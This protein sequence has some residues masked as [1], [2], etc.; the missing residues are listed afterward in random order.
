MEGFG[1][2]RMSPLRERSAFTLIELL[3]ILAIVGVL[4]ALLLVAV[5]RA[6]EAAARTQ[7][8]NNLR[9]ISLAASNFAASHDGRLPNVAGKPGSL[10]PKQSILVTLLP[11]V[12]QE[13]LYNL[14]ASKTSEALQPVRIYM[15]PSDPSL[16]Y[17]R[18]RTW[19]SSYAANA[20]VFTGNP[21]FSSTFADGT[22]NTIVF[23][24][25]YAYCNAVIFSYE[26]YTASSGHHRA[27][28]A[29][30]GPNVEQ[31]ENP[32]DAY[33]KT[34]GYPPVSCSAYGKDWTFQVMPIIDPPPGRDP[35]LP[36][37]RKGCDPGLANTPHPG[38]MLTAWG[39]G[40]VRTIARGVSP[41]VYWGAVSP[42]SGEI[43][44][45]GW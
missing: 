26:E 9:Q 19:V 24:E 10:N 45:L 21:S 37:M 44:N 3:V 18:N 39:D 29:D 1:F 20:Q 4:L 25:H 36:Y 28:F 30:G 6:R 7:S 12:G 16:G 33:P 14:Y 5:Q 38:G 43:L 35:N 15:S 11:Y 41:H 31:H 13:N 23:G 27:T 17:L 8:M 34:Q 2:M 42:A 32:G 40:S 22:S